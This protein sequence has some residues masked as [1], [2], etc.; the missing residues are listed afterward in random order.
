MN[1]T[2]HP[3]SRGNISALWVGGVG[4]MEADL[5]KRAVFAYE[6]IPAAG[7]HGVGLRR[8]PGNLL[9][10]GQGFMAS[11]KILKRVQPD[12]VFFT[13]GYL[14]VPMALAA[15][16]RRLTQ[17][18]PQI[19]L[20][21]P[22]IE[23]GLALKT[24]ARF[25]DRIAV[26][27]ETTQK[28]YSSKARIVVTG[29]PTRTEHRRWIGRKDEARK[30]FGLKAD[31][32]VTLVFGGSK[33]A[34]SINRA[35]LHHLADLLSL[36]QVIHITGAL[37]W[38]EDSTAAERILSKLPPE[39]TEKY[40]AYP[41][42]HDEMSAAFAAAD[43]TICRAGASVLGELPLFELP[44]IL[45][46]YP[47]AWRYQQVNAVYLRDKGAAIII[48][49]QALMEQLVSEVQKL[50]EKK[51]KLQAMREAM[52]SMSKP[53]AAKSIGELILQMATRKEQ[54]DD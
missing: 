16:M 47:H 2:L 37:D 38:E 22:D 19:L 6:E 8:L 14:A 46:P 11:R 28:Y 32:P 50:Y 49:D 51:E 5:V 41:Y 1:D 52:K 21:V 15:R 17:K 53:D 12:V 10:I 42:L 26:T 3:L 24:L 18:S 31:E 9:K 34:R 45:V 43:L 27:T 13:G 25:A 7:V 36:T 23:P 48:E 29:Y 20:Y 54:W 39:L 4:G 44:A 30:R 33:G 35:V 40:H